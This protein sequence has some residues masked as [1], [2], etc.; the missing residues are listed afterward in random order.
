MSPFKEPQPRKVS[1]QEQHEVAMRKQP[2]DEANGFPRT[3]KGNVM[4]DV[5]FDPYI[6]KQEAVWEM[7]DS[8]FNRELSV[9]RQQGNAEGQAEAVKDFRQALDANRADLE[10]RKAAL[11]SALTYWDK[12][13]DA[14]RSSDNV[15]H[16]AAKFETY[17]R[18]GKQ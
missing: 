4:T 5:S 2:T 16:V 14:K 8:E 12:D 3:H 15:I 10:Y 18:E 9:A 7:T 13:G 11:D 6:P 17:L 1:I